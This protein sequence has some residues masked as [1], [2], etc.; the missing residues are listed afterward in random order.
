MQMIL[1]K[2]IYEPHPEEWVADKSVLTSA[3]RSWEIDHL[4]LWSE[5]RIIQDLN[6]HLSAQFEFADLKRQIMNEEQPVTSPRVAGLR[7]VR[8]IIR[9]LFQST[10]LDNNKLFVIRLKD[11]PGLKSLWFLRVHPPV[12]TTP[13]GSPMLLVTANDHRLAQKFVDRKK[14]DQGKASEDFKRVFVDGLDSTSMGVCPM[15]LESD[16]EENLLRYLLRSNAS[17]L[18][19]ANGWPIEDLPKGDDSPWLATFISPSYIDQAGT[20]AEMEDLVSVT[21]QITTGPPEE[22]Q[23]IPVP[24][25]SASKLETCSKC[26]TVKAGLKRCSRCKTVKYCSVEC[27][28]SDWV[29]HKPSCV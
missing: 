1:M 17:K 25:E 26:Q 21:S 23:I 20:D 5:G 24:E 19:P 2:A 29:A 13:S 28:R 7:G 11:D 3:S 12:R 15:F 22:N 6:F 14:L 8:E 27:Q 9:T 10:L 18:W 16:E 4:K